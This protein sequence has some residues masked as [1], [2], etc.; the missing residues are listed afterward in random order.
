MDIVTLL[1]ELAEIKAQADLLRIDQQ[2]AIDGV[3]TPEIKAQVAGVEA[4]FAPALDTAAERSADLEKRIKT[5][6]TA[7]GESVKG[8]RLQAVFSIRT[9]WDTKALNGFAA[10]HP[11]IEPFRKTS[12]SV[13]I[14]VVK[15]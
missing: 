7:L 3:L 15:Q 9:S 2:K 1:D 11:E 13:S 10:A 6:T 4:E 14:R 8:T 5:A 12:Q